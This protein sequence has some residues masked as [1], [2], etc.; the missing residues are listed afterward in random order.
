LKRLDELLLPPEL[1]AGPMPT[2]KVPTNHAAKL[3][4]AGVARAVDSL[5]AK[6]L[7]MDYFTVV[8]VKD[9]GRRQRPIMW[10][11][12]YLRNSRYISAFTLKSCADYRRSVLRGTHGVAF[13]LASSFW[14]VDVSHLNLFLI[15]EDGSVMQVTRM[16][17]GIDMASEIMQLILQTLAD[18]DGA[19]K[20]HLDI[21]I[22]NVMCVGSAKLCAQW[23]AMFKKRCSACGVTLNTED[24]NQVRRH[25]TFCG[26]V[27]DFDRKTVA[28]KAL[29]LAKIDRSYV[30]RHT[31]TGEQLE[32]HVSRLLY[33]STVLA[34]DLSASYFLVKAYR[35]CL[36]A[37]AKHPRNWTSTATLPAKALSDLDVLTRTVLENKPVVVRDKPIT[38]DG[39]TPDAVIVSDATPTCGGGILF[40]PGRLPEAFGC[41]W[42]N[43]DINDAES[44]GAALLLKRWA[45][46]LTNLR[47]LLRIDNTTSLHRILRASS[48]GC[49]EVNR[50]A[51]GLIDT[52]VEHGFK[53]RVE[54]IS[55]ARNPADA[56]SRMAVVND[57]LVADLLEEAWGRRGSRSRGGGWRRSTGQ[58]VR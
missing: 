10:P 56:I 28:V 3:V 4:S 42:P 38:N 30:A 40:M 7:W 34:I 41:R 23:A 25:C 15:C 20:D 13:D 19:Y 24:T 44:L 55:T 12:H 31:W 57:K 17:F 54:Y 45:P 1:E 8:E 50:I 39:F 21:H 27:F 53:L 32:S 18:V 29:T 58:R 22:D 51:A 9:D 33:C 36:S 46:Q 49:L 52:A 48:G 16:P 26:I 14:Q 47:V 43:I 6:V 35:R 11:R 37:F 2:L 5:P